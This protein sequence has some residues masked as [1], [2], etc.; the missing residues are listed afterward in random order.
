[1]FE[2]ATL[3]EV[4]NPALT[5]RKRIRQYLDEKGVRHALRGY[6]YLVKATEICL[7]DSSAKF[8]VCKLYARIAGY[9]DG[10][11]KSR[12]ER[13]IRHALEDCTDISTTNSEFICHMVD[14][15]EDGI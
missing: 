11:T 9:F 12:V 1:M 2:F 6:G 14:E 8:H 3:Q 13:A 4:E 15:L 7:A 10:A 5:T